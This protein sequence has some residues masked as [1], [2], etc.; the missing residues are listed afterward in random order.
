MCGQPCIYSIAAAAR[1][2]PPLSGE[3]HEVARE[4]PDIGL[5]ILGTCNLIRNSL[6]CLFRG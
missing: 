1:L 2:P 3:E 4:A 6:G 5:G